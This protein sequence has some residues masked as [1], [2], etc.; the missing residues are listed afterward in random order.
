[1]C[2]S[3]KVTPA[4]A[5]TMNLFLTYKKRSRM[6]DRHFHTRSSLFYNTSARHKR[7]ECDTI[8]TPLCMSAERTTPVWHECVTHDTL[9]TRVKKF[10]F[11]NDMSES[12][13][14]H[15]Y[16]NYMANERLYGEKR[17]HS[18]NYLGSVPW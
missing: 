16:I 18:Q 6:V 17:F 15:P 3:L 10:D 1:M 5:F 7:Q 9:A 4:D 12:I 14:S 8:A 13:F 2:W 11:D